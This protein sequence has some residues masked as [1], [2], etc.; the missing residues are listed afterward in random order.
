MYYLCLKI[1]VKDYINLVWKWW[2][3]Y[4]HK[5]SSINCLILKDMNSVIEKG[6]KRI[7]LAKEECHEKYLYM[8]SKLQ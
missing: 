6:E 3:I 7:I 5:L 4:L 8:S 1:I 2:V